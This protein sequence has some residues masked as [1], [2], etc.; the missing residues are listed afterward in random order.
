MKRATIDS[1][2]KEALA[3]VEQLK[4]E[5][6]LSEYTITLYNAND[7][8]LLL[9]EKKNCSSCKGLKH[10]KNTNEGYALQYENDDFILTSCP[11][12]K[13]AALKSKENQKIKTLFISKSILSASLMDYNETTPNR[14]KIYEF[15]LKFI[16]QTRQG[17][18]SKG[19]FLYGGFATGKTF[20][21]GCIA[22]EL[23]K[24]DIESLIIYFPDLVVELKNA[25]GSDRLEQLMNY[26]KSVEVL[27]LDDLGSENMTPWLRDEV[28]GPVLNYRLMEEKPVFISS[29]LNPAEDLLEHLSITKTSTDSLKGARIKSRLEGLVIPIELDNGKYRR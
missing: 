3:F 5:P 7:F 25:I 18:F 19:L 4:K 1:N 14:K 29:N 21:L 24:N 22:N 12:K 6:L 10:C 15:I 11:Y 27:I 20:I 16:Q 2:E 9:E 17:I 13:E 8:A 28:L 23:A 26:L